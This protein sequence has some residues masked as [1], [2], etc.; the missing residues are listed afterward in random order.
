MFCIRDTEQRLDKVLD[1]SLLDHQAMPGFED[2]KFES[3]WRFVKAIT[4]R[5]KKEMYSSSLGFSPTLRPSVMG[6]FGSPE[7]KPSYQ[8]PPNSSSPEV[9]SSMSRSRTP[10]V[11]NLRLTLA[12]T[13]S[14]PLPIQPESFS[15]KT[16][17]SILS[18]TL[19]ILQQ[20]DFA[21]HPALLV[22]AFSQLLY[23]L[24]SELFN[25]ILAKVSTSTFQTCNH[26]QGL[27]AL[28]TLPMPVASRPDPVECVIAGRLGSYKPTSA[29]TC[30]Y[31]FSAIERASA[32]VTMPL[33]GV[34]Y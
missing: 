27:C 12:S 17:T 29:A 2:V 8:G 19:Y 24:A 3:E 32:V 28:E 10:S 26:A 18:N 5:A 14:T 7:R 20:Y 11:P 4:S 9:S 33:L 30:C 21:G 1:A 23:W 15:P 13:F 22:Q 25:R 34:L 16:V 31:A 6:L